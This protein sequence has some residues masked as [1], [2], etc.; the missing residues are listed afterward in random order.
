MHTTI[1]GGSDRPKTNAFNHPAMALPASM[2][3]SGPGLLTREDLR[4]LVAAMVD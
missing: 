2:R 3:K 1:M 4:H